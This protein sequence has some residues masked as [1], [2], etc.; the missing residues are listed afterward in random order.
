MA[1]GPGSVLSASL[2]ALNGAAAA[3]RRQG[4]QGMLRFLTQKLRYQSLNE[5]YPLSQTVIPTDAAAVVACTG[6][7]ADE[8]DDGG[9]CSRGE[10]DADGSVD[11]ACPMAGLA[12]AACARAGGCLEPRPATGSS[13]G[14]TCRTGEPSATGSGAMTVSSD[15]CRRGEGT[16]P[17][18]MPPVSEA[19]AAA[20][21]GR[22]GDSNR[23]GCCLQPAAA[24]SSSGQQLGCEE[25]LHRPP[26][27]AC[28]AGAGA[29]ASAGVGEK[30]AKRK[31]QQ[32][33]QQ[34]Q[35]GHAAEG[36]SSATLATSCYCSTDSS[37]E[38]VQ[39]LLARRMPSGEAAAAAAATAANA[40]GAAAA[41]G[42]FACAAAVG[43]RYGSGDAGGG[44]DCARRPLASS[45][46]LHPP[47]EPAADGSRRAGLSNFAL[48]HVDADESVHETGSAAVHAT[49]VASPRKRHCADGSGT[50]AGP[51]CTGQ[52][53]IGCSGSS[54]S[55][56][57]LIAR[58]SL[59]LE[60]MHQKAAAL[61]RHYPRTIRIRCWNAGGN[62]NG[63]KPTVLHNPA[64]FLFRSI[65]TKLVASP[66]TPVERPSA[67]SV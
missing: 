41:T 25:P 37:D 43:G 38:E 9:S 56:A 28:R 60:K 63:M 53:S 22:S 35:V 39:E 15:R 36:G 30:C 10:H 26:P 33:Q 51:Q 40:S 52:H 2:R 19:A 20:A 27:V 8:D 46:S 1:V 12:V 11:G 47:V 42:A 34:Q 4:A 58:P 48:A 61:K 55:G 3:G 17:P 54:S 44:R 23:A 5:I 13:R 45:A 18:P 7:A 62:L 65:E 50:Q 24:L 59:D 21:A 29:A 16:Q 66:L 57:M 6:Q 14:E 49:V 32:Q 67:C 64:D 31:R